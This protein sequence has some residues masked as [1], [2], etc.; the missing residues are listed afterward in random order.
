MQQLKTWPSLANGNGMHSSTVCRRNKFKC[1]CHVSKHVM[2][3]MRKSYTY[4][5][6]VFNRFQHARIWI[7]ETFPTHRYSVCYIEIT[8]RKLDVANKYYE[9]IGA[10]LSPI[11][12]VCYW[13]KAAACKQIIW[14]RKGATQLFHY[15]PNRSSSQL[16]TGESH[17]G[18]SIKNILKTFITQIIG[19]HD[20]E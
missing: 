5:L 10:N 18:H 8:C 11:T 3:S 20:Y 15:L 9:Q 4:S 6:M 16:F 19:M 2:N 12:S 17:S 13:R 1:N 7:L 14:H